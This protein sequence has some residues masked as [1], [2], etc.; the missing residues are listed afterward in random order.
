MARPVSP[1]AAITLLER[2]T[3]PVLLSKSVANLDKLKGRL[4]PTVKPAIDSRLL[5][6]K[7]KSPQ[8]AFLD[9]GLTRMSLDKK[10][11]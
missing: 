6:S 11:D 9:S 4:N 5:N 10:L 3:D 1:E 8:G 7:F 2:R